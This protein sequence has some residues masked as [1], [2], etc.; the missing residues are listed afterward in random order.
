MDLNE[1][2][3]SAKKAWAA[4]VNTFLPG[5]SFTF[6]YSGEDF[7]LSGDFDIRSV[8]YG[9]ATHA[10]FAGQCKP[11]LSIGDHSIRGAHLVDPKWRLAFLLHDCGEFLFGD[12]PT[13]FKTLFDV[14]REVACARWVIDHVNQMLPHGVEVGLQV[15]DLD[16]RMPPELKTVDGRLATSEAVRVLPPETDLDGWPEP[17]PDV[18][19]WKFL[20][21]EQAYTRFCR[22]FWRYLD[23]AGTHDHG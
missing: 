18:Q 22:D 19:D 5:H 8:A 4:Y 2:T 13:P 23:E 21:V 1:L 20:T 16:V 11:W 15:G 6:D 17:Y 14:K 10:R 3:P 12:I 9:L 7:V